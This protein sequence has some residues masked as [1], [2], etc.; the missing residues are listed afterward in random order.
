MRYMVVRRQTTAPATQVPSWVDQA[1]DAGWVAGTWAR[2]SG[3]SPSHGLSPSTAGHINIDA[4]EPVVG[5]T[6]PGAGQ[7]SV[8][9][10]WAGG[11]FAT[12]YGT[13]GSLV[14]WNGGHDNY[15]GNEVYAFDM[16]TRDWNRLTDPYPTPGFPISEGWW[17]AH[18]GHP[19]GSPSVP[20]TY[21]TLTYD[22]S[23]NSLWSMR[24]QSNNGGSADPP[25][26][27]RFD[28]ATLQWTRG[29]WGT[30]AGTFAAGG[31]SSYDAGRDLILM[32]GGG[33]LSVSDTLIT[34]TP[35][36]GAFA[37]VAI[38]SSG[39]SDLA[40]TDGVA[41]YSTTDDF[42]AI[43]RG[44][45]GA[46]VYGIPGASLGTT[47]VALTTSGTGPTGDSHGWQWSAL[48]ES[49]IRYPTNGSSVYQLTKSGTGAWQSST[50]VWS[51]LTTASTNAPEDME[52]NGCYSKFQLVQYGTVEMAVVVKRTGDTG[53]GAVYA[54][55]LS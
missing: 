34:F 50:W 30:S 9:R 51:L 39:H 24:R 27:S 33:G 26:A 31:W 54:F 5:G 55:R 1:I 37:T 13:Y 29:T 38:S 11:A 4:L 32:H 17:P 16:A 14:M 2:I 19:N 48:R 40:Q 3:T 28:F 15:Y 8:V 7:Y 20:H 23:R 44:S 53:T 43:V 6:N 22:A 35:A 25:S 36:T 45:N 47:R 21:D 42:H 46:T 12:G 49:F 41:D 52:A 10:A 18:T